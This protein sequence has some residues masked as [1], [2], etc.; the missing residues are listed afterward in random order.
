MPSGSLKFNA[1]PSNTKLRRVTEH[2]P[3]ER[4]I[5]LLQGGGGY[6]QSAQKLPLRCRAGAPKPYCAKQATRRGI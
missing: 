4:I 6:F 5:L 1:S 2:P 3:F